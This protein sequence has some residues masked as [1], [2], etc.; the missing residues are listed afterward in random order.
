MKFLR[1]FAEDSSSNDNNMK[2]G[3]FDGKKIVELSDSIE[4]ILNNWESKDY[5]ENQMIASYSIDEITFA[6]VCEPTKIICIGLNY[7]DH[8]EELAMELPDEPKIFLK[9]PSSVIACGDDIIYPSMSS[10]VDYEAEL[11]IVISKTGKNIDSVDATDYVGGYTIIND[12][13][14]RDLQ[15]KDEQWTRAKSFDTFAPIGPFIETE[16]DPTNQNISLSLNGEVKQNSN[17]KNMIFSPFELVEF[18]SNIMTLNSGDIIA[19]GTPSGVG[20]MKKG[21]IAEINVEN[22]GT[23]KNNLV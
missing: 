20:Q 17:T 9:P 16:M 8:A 14:A 4:N 5:L 22:I 6:P 13:T 1:F 10:E 18:I 3:Y 11:A 2:T 7:K 19:T 12:V 23:L 21:D 15:R